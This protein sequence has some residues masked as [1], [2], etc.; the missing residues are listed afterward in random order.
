MD[1]ASRFLKGEEIEKQVT[2]HAWDIEAADLSL[3]FDGAL[4]VVMPD[5]V[6][7]IEIGL[8]I[9]GRISEP[10]R[11]ATNGQPVHAASRISLTTEMMVPFRSS[12]WEQ[13][14]K[15]EFLEVQSIG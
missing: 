5:C 2:I 4:L 13:S 8:L 10:G 7:R 1:L 14:E 3:A 11:R 15:P 6:Y 12:T 9:E